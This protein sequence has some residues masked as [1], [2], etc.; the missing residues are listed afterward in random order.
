MSRIGNLLIDLPE[1]CTREIFET[2]LE[3]KG[4]KLER[5][6]STGQATRPGQWY[7][8]E[9]DEWVVLLSGE[10]KLRYESG[11]AVALRPGDHVLIPRHKRH[12]VEWTAKGVRTVWLA[13]HF[14][15]TTDEH[16]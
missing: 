12:R 1:N 14:D 9:Q 3:A 6:V 13:L 11:D 5:I 2:L 10:A 4:F 8:Q 15:L 16:G 7:D